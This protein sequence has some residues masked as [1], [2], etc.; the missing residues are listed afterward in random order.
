MVRKRYSRQQIA[1]LSRKKC[2]FCEEENYDLL[3]A[4][5]IIPGEQGGKYNDHNILVLCSN[6]HRK[7]HSGSLQILG[8]FMSTRGWVIRYVEDGKEHWK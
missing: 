8:K 7:T 4:H 6:C 1:K 2:Y 5:R 3:D